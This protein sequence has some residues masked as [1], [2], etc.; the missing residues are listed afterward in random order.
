VKQ[1]RFLAF[2]TIG[3]V[4]ASDDARAQASQDVGV[5]TVAADEKAWSFSA[6]VLTYFLAD[7][8]DYAQPTIS[9]DRDRLHL[10]GRYNYE[11]QRTGSAWLGYNFSVGDDVELAL[12]P[13]FG[14][15]FGDAS[16]IAPGY[17]ASLSWRN[18]ALDSESEYVFD[19]QESSDSFFYTW[20]E[21][22]WTP[23]EWLRVGLA[24]Q[25]TK[26]YK[27]DLDIQRGILVGVSYKRASFTTYIL[28]PDASRPTVILGISVR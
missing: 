6:S 24:V 20:S 19:A 7:E 1:V 21:L 27:T 9:A 15:V 4:L 18:L 23:I 17:K 8:S 11:S 2:L 3:V 10:E 12:T 25:R 22:G 26:A 14:V 13:M 16:G 28:N 5:S